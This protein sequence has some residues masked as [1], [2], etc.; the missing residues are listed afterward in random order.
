MLNF[1]KRDIFIYNETSN[2]ATQVME[3]GLSTRQSHILTNSSMACSSWDRLLSHIQ[4]QNSSVNSEMLFVLI[5][6]ASFRKFSPR[7]TK[8][9]FKDVAC[10]MNFT[11]HT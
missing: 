1:G 10:V 4:V 6:P 9:K 5:Y 7:L 8:L 2:P 3:L 11:L